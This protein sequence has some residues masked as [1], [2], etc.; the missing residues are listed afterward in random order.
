MTTLYMTIGLPG[1]GKSTWAA[2]TGFQIYSS[3]AIREELGLDPTKKEDNNKTFEELHKRIIE[4]LSSGESAIYDA[5]NMSR[6]KRMEFLRQVSQ[7]PVLRVAVLFTTPLDICIER[8][9]KRENPVGKDVIMRMIGGFN[10][11]WLYEGW[12]QIACVPNEEAYVYPTDDMDQKSKRHAL[13][14]IGHQDAAEKFA[15]EHNYGKFVQGAALYHDIGKR[16]T[17][18]ISDDGEAHYYNHH[19]VGAYL[20]LSGFNEISMND[21]YVGNLIN[22][23]MAPYVEWK[24]SPQKMDKDHNMM[25]NQMFGDIWRLHECDEAAH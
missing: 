6:K 11:P 3:D 7:L 1:S 19:N 21:L 22:W 4:A 2:T 9:S 5:T 10:A 18:T 14:L 23:H 15:F 16:I 13:S 12:N 8:D 17:Q 20:Y 25:G 24:Q